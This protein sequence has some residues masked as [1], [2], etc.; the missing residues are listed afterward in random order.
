M[1]EKDLISVIIPVYNLAPYIQRCL[2]SIYSNT[3]KNLEIICIDDGSTDD[4]YKILQAQKDKRVK[5]FTQQNA[6]VSAAR[7]RGLEFSEGEIIAF[8]DGDDWIH[9]QYFELMLKA[10]GDADVVCC[11]FENVKI[12]TS[13]FSSEQS[14]NMRILNVRE[15]K[16]NFQIKSFVWGKLYR[17]NAIGN[18]RFTPGIKMAED[19]LFNMQILMHDRLV[20]V[21]NN[22]LYFYFSRD[23]SV[24]HSIDA[25]MYAVGNEFLRLGELEKNQDM[26]CE[27]ISS[28]LSFRYLNMFSA[29]SEQTKRQANEKLDECR[30]SIQW[31]CNIK[32]KLLLV[33]AR[34]PAI[35]RIYRLVSDPT[36]FAWEKSQKQR[37]N[38]G[39]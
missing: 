27:A 12:F 1:N 32:L 2:D 22:K 5:I 8:I 28:F 11:G 17:R 31:K 18:I 34:I 20:S 35:Y 39:T 3:Y 36:M 9:P 33:M 23:N 26:I 4:S 21:I 6:G 29:D 30:K 15:A 7:N 14:N 13:F 10:L 24:V 19:K 37:K 25:Q 38:K 16:K